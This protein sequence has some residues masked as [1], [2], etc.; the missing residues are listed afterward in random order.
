MTR[1]G[2]EI[3]AESTRQSLRS[4]R[5]EWETDSV[6]I[7]GTNADYAVYLEYGRGPIE[8]QDAEALR[9]ENQDGDVIYRASVD[10]HE[11]YPFFRP[12]LREFDA[13][14]E[15]FIIDNTGYTTLQEIPNGDE[16]IR[17]IAV[18]LE[19]QIKANASA[20]SATDRSPGTHPS[21]PK[22]DTGN[23]VASIQSIKIQ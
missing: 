6:F 15:T 19:N 12:A 2:I 10:G 9:F 8:A 3:D 5:N 20:E 23:L 18:A 11:P 1:F 17:A 13:N 4:L 7:T 21:H 22:R 16:L 14:P